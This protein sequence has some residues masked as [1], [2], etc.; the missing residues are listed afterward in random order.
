MIAR[1]ISFFLY[2]FII[3]STIFGQIN[4]IY[5]PAGFNNP[6]LKSGKFITSLY[7]YNYNSGFEYGGQEDKLT[8]Y[9]LNLVGYLGLTDQITLKTNIV[10][11]PTQTYSKITKGGVGEDKSDLYLSPQ[12]VLSYRPSNSIEIFGDFFYQNQTVVMGNK[13]VY[14]D[15]PIGVDGNGNIIY[16]KRLITQ[17]SLGNSISKTTT[18]RMGISYFGNLW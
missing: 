1:I 8:N 7:Y 4:D 10:Y 17:P 13:S 15:V 5:I 9:N 14:Q 6:F 2:M 16:E 11:S 3:S 12:I 18:F